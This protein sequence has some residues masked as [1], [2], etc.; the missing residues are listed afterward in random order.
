[1][2]RQEF[3]IDLDPEVPESVRGTRA[4]LGDALGGL[5][6]SALSRELADEREQV[7]YSDQED[8]GHRVITT[9]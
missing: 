3:G 6:R 8:L 2:L 1:M 4:D 9:L 5:V 7:G